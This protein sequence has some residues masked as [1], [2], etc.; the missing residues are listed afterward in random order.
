[1]ADPIDRGLEARRRGDVG[2][3]TELLGRAVRLAHESGS[4]S[5]THLLRGVVEIEDEA[6]GTVRLRRDVSREAEMTLD[7]RSRL[8]TRARNPATGQ[9]EQ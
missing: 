9:P 5:T 6:S 4:V 8:T 1:M 7:A 3:A 2:R